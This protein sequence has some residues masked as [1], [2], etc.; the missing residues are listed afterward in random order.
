MY[1]HVHYTAWYIVAE[2]VAD[3]MYMYMYIYIL[4]YSFS[5]PAG[6]NS[7]SGHSAFSLPAGQNSISSHSS[8]LSKVSNH[9]SS[10]SPLPSTSHHSSLPP[11]SP[12]HSHSPSPILPGIGRVS[13]DLYPANLSESPPPLSP[14][15]AAACGTTVDQRLANMSESPT[16]KKIASP[17]RTASPRTGPPMTLHTVSDS[18][19]PHYHTTHVALCPSRKPLPDDKTMVVRSTA[20]MRPPGVKQALLQGTFVPRQ[21]YGG[22][23]AIRPHLP[24]E[25][26]TEDPSEDHGQPR[27]H[28]VAPADGRPKQQPIWRSTVPGEFPS[29]GNCVLPHTVLFSQMVGAGNTALCIRTYMYM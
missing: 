10:H 21:H 20:Y 3:N 12:S 7:I 28:P 27:P 14:L 9:T 25:Q 5:L 11:S 1:I 26:L 19:S 29:E 15:R 22:Y 17:V 13:F 2:L 4:A 16:R 23:P 24:T 8:I 18:D 6:Q